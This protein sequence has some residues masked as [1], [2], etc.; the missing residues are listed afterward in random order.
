MNGPAGEESLDH[1]GV[2]LGELPPSIGRVLI[3][4]LDDDDSAGEGVWDQSIRLAP[5]STIAANFLEFNPGTPQK[6]QRQGLVQVIE[7]LLLVPDSQGAAPPRLP[8]LN[9]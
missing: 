2:E 8:T 5:A 1:R 4:D 6:R 9:E 7:N 3:L